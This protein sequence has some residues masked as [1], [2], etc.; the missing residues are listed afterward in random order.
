MHGNFFHPRRFGRKHV[1]LTEMPLP[2]MVP[3]IFPAKANVA[4]MLFFAR[5]SESIGPGPERHWRWW[6][7][8]VIAVVTLSQFGR[9][10]A[11][12]QG[13]FHLHWQ[14]GGR[15]AAGE[16]PYADTGLDLPYLPFWGVVHAPLSYLPMHLAQIAIL[17]IFGIA[18]Y[19]LFRTLSR[20]SRRL[21]PI[22]E[23]HAFW[24]T[25]LTVLLASRFL[26]RD[27]LEC[28]VNLALVALAWGAFWCWRN[29]RDWAG[30]SLLGFAIALKLT[31]ALFLAWFA[32]KRQWKI[33]FA[34]TLVTGILLLSPIVLSRA[35]RCLW[36]CIASGGIMP[37]R[38]F[39][40]RTRSTAFWAKNR[41][42]TC[43]SAPRWRGF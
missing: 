10:I 40:R 14:F 11:E 24:A 5:I 4:R 25:I 28:G 9:V 1:F 6:A 17:P 43:R 32:W 21:L 33:A 3:A 16:Y 26:I 38:A 29:R 35:G 37:P 31:P 34:T 20:M 36:M 12:P 39:W 41:F 2:S 18:A 7:V 23:R 22:D 8:G 42:R 15:L 13:D 19:C 27:I 30:G